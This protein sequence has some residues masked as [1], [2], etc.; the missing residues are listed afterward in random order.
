MINERSKVDGVAKAIQT[1]LLWF[2]TII[3][4]LSKRMPLSI[5]AGGPTMY[6]AYFSRNVLV[7]FFMALLYTPC[8]YI[9]VSLPFSQPCHGHLHGCRMVQLLGTCGF[10][11]AM[12]E[13][14]NIWLILGAD[15][16]CFPMEYM[17]S[18]YINKK[19]TYPSS[20]ITF[21]TIQL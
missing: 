11:E 10:I 16:C 21:R 15:W 3:F 9:I 12:I 13:I 1:L 18:K 2:T 7:F 20:A 14:I 4:R 8:L 17:K 19:A 6:L 5:L